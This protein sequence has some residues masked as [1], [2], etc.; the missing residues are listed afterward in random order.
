MTN[1]EHLQQLIAIDTD[2]CIIWPYARNG[3]GGYGKL[4]INGKKHGAHVVALELTSPRPPGKVCSIHGNWVEGAKLCSAHGECHNR[5]C[6]NPKHL[7][8]KTYAENF[9]DRK[10]DGTDPIGER[11]PNSKLTDDEVASIL[12]EWKGKQ[13]NM[14]PRTGPTTYELAA[15]YGVS[16]VQIGNIVNNKSRRVVA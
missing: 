15:K 9:A 11:N 10:R 2:D 16:D 5:T 6:V 12:A 13:H 8:W 7:S 14:R 4:K 1:Y 3:K